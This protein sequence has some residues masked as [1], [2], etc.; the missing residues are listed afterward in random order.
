LTGTEQRESNKFGVS[1][2][3]GLEMDEFF[4]TEAAEGRKLLFYPY[5]TRK[6]P[7]PPRQVMTYKDPAKLDDAPSL[8]FHLWRLQI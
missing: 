6:L 2:C 7:F 3:K 4:E 5:Q 1:K 8:L